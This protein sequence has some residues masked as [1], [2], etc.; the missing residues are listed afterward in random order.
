[1]ASSFVPL[2]ISVIAEVVEPADCGDGVDFEVAD[3][4]TS[5]ELADVEPADGGGGVARN[6][7]SQDVLLQW[8]VESSP[9]ELG[10]ILLPES[11]VDFIIVALLNSYFIIICRIFTLGRPFVLVSDKNSQ[12][13]SKIKRPSPENI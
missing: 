13:G 5:S 12:S 11:I 4:E 2:M 3:C 10:C 8:G 7:T 9:N 6:I 1:M